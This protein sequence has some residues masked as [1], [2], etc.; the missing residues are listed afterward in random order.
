[1]FRV[2]LVSHSWH[3]AGVIKYNIKPVPVK[4]N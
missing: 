4:Y 3:C 2:V 1:M